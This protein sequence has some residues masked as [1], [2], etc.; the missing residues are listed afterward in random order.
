MKKPQSVFLALPNLQ[1]ALD[2]VCRKQS[3]P[4]GTRL[5]NSMD[6]VTRE[7]R[8]F[9]MTFH[10]KSPYSAVA[11]VEL[12][13]EADVWTELFGEELSDEYTLDVTLTGE[14]ALSLIDKCPQIKLMVRQV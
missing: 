4:A 1:L 6:F 2:V 11:L 7:P 3:P 9:A 14:Q 12:V 13:D 10:D 5:S 8:P